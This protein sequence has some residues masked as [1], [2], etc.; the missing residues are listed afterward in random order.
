[1]RFQGQVAVVL[2]GSVSVC[3]EAVSKEVLR[4]IDPTRM[5]IPAFKHREDRS[6]SEA[7]IM[8]SVTSLHR[9]LR[10]AVPILFAAL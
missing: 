2:T 8:V 3:Y 7:G 1:M 9:G 6:S 10:T 5:H 4:A